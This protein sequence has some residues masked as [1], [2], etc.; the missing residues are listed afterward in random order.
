[1]RV[2][3]DK[4]EECSEHV[5][6][7]VKMEE[8]KINEDIDAGNEYLK[9]NTILYNKKVDEMHSMLLYTCK[10][11]FFLMQDK[12]GINIDLKVNY[13]IVHYQLCYSSDWIVFM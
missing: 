6:S 2:I 1:M 10:A 13:V 3:L 8:S 11:F 9:D 5:E 4:I 7:D 12:L